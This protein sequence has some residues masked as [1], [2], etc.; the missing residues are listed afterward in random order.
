MSAEKQKSDDR[1]VTG[2]NRAAARG[3]GTR[4]GGAKR[5]APQV[6]CVPAQAT[7]RSPRTAVSLHRPLGDRGEPG[8]KRIV[9]SGEMQPVSEP[10]PIWLAALLAAPCQ[11]AGNGE[12]HAVRWNCASGRALYTNGGAHTE[13]IEP[14]GV[15]LKEGHTLAVCWAP[16]ETTYSLEVFRQYDQCA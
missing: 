10:V 13:R 11:A 5:A 9:S 7:G 6:H 8:R 15:T 4:A 16:G 2:N 12:D 14:L 3:A 1:R